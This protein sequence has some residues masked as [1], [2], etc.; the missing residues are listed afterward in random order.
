MMEQKL[1]VLWVTENGCE[2]DWEVDYIRE[3]LDGMSDIPY[4]MHT[5]KRMDQVI[6]NALVVINHSVPYKEYLSQ[7][8]R[9]CVPFGVIHLSDEWF[10]DD[11][12][13]YDYKMCKF[14][15]RNYYDERF[16]SD[17]VSFLPLSYKNGFWKDGQKSHGK[18][19]SFNE[20]EYVWSFAGAKRAD[21]TDRE[22]TLALFAELAPYK[23]HFETGN[24]F[25]SP[26]DGL[27]T[28]E[29][30]AL[31][32]STQFGLC[33]RG[34]SNT[35]SGD[36]CRV[37]E[38]LEC[39]CIPVVLQGTTSTGDTY[40]KKLYGR[41]PPFIQGRDWSECL[42]NVKDLLAMGSEV[43]ELKRQECYAF[44]QEVKKDS[45]SRIGALLRS[46]GI[47]PAPNPA[48][49]LD[50]GRFKAVFVARHAMHEE[51]I[52]ELYRMNLRI[53]NYIPWPK[54]AV[55]DPPALDYMFHCIEGYKDNYDW[56]INMDDDAFLCDFKALF[57][58]M[59]FME[60]NKYDICGMPDGLTLT[61]RDIFNPCSMNP[62]FNVIQLKTIKHKLPNGVRDMVAPYHPKLLEHVDVTKYHPE[63]W[64]KTAEQLQGNE[65][66]VSYEPYYNWFHAVLPKSKV[67]WLYGQSYD[68][69]K[70]LPLYEVFIVDEP[71]RANTW[72]NNKKGI[73]FDDDPWTTV[74]YNHEGKEVCIHTWYSRNY[75]TEFDPTLP[76]IPN[77]A[78]MD[79]IFQL[80]CK[81]L[82]VL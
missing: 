54:V 22:H 5:V 34:I 66:S 52:H 21:K 2:K 20:R 82:G 4:E 61:P 39:G 1:Q 38:S 58:L 69:D 28:Q 44:W 29:Y 11:V 65:Y 40:W 13:F 47:Y 23:T 53:L 74:L 24:S 63:M 31:L 19:T 49:G 70:K 55:Q 73:L 41:D 42:Q 76:I 33:P 45:M 81:K 10:N 35:S 3:L 36:T 17:K 25:S 80:A 37:T 46:T 8:E 26:V 18:E 72:P 16:E 79:R 30:R 56:V 64:G 78:R 57:D 14:V 48:A 32:L 62:F 68:Y 7:Y 43:C 77:V 60:E 59:V 12:S 51:K 75:G 67:L 71:R 50:W 27:S 15:L 9:R 6:A